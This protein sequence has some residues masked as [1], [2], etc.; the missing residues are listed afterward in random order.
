M[1]DARASSPR[2]N[3]FTDV[4]AVSNAL[5]KKITSPALLR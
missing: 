2:Y 3:N 5:E 1:D 4:D